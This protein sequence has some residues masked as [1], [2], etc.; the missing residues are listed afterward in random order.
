MALPRG[1]GR[2]GVM[3]CRLTSDNNYDKLSSMMLYRCMSSK[4]FRR[5]KIKNSPFRILGISEDVEFAVAKKAFL[6]IA[7]KNHPDMVRDDDQQN[8]DK[9][10]EIFM[11][12]R[13]AF[14]S[15]VE[16]PDGSILLREEVEHIENF[17]AWFRQETGVDTPFQFDMDP[18]TMKEVAEMTDTIGGGLDRDGGMW[19]LANMVTNTV[20]SG[21]DTGSILKLQA[22]DVVSSS[23]SSSP[24][25]EINGVLRRKRPMQR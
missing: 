10:R 8:K 24:N 12:A 22:G 15:L 18:E 19:T 21:G 13:T 20:K 2:G 6:D 7:M 17:D 14:E 25:P 5:K 23:S 9:L 16:G 4:Y 3:L 11:E 1:P